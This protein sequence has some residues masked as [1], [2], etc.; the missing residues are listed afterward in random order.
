MSE[1]IHTGLKRTKIL[2]FFLKNTDIFVDIESDTNGYA[3]IAMRHTSGHFMSYLTTENYVVAE[4]LGW[5]DSKNQLFYLIAKPDATQRHLYATTMDGEKTCLT[6]TPWLWNSASVSPNGDW[7]VLYRDGPSVPEQALVRTTD[8]TVV[9]ELEDNNYLKTLLSEYQ[10]PARKFVTVP[11]SKGDFNGYLLQPPEFDEF[12]QYPL[13]MKVYGGPGSQMVTQQ[14]L[15]D[16]FLIYLASNGYVVGSVDGRGTGYRGDDFMKQIYLDMGLYACDDQI[17]SANYLKTYYDYID[18]KN[19]GIWGW[20]FGGY[21]TALVMAN[22]ASSPFDI[23]IS[24]A[25]VTDWALYDSIYTERYM[26]DPKTNPVGYEATSVLY[27][28]SKMKSHFLLVHGTAD[29]NVQFMNTCDLNEL[30]VENNIQFDTMFYVNRDHSISGNNGREH[31]YRMM[32]NYIARYL[33]TPL[34]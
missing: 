16:N 33:G 6:N 28:A 32:A 22:G 25:P 31:L 21:V 34:P 5:S 14:Y 9:R 4:I 19:I 27:Q 3:Q 12:G 20:S 7:Y 8:F 11:T 30:L 10:M 2:F 18:D 29:D 15:T 24:V 17:D 23:G 13:F 26:Q 1:L